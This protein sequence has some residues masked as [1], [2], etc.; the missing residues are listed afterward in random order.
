M[1]VRGLNFQSLG[2]SER[3][4]FCFKRQ[5]ESTFLLEAELDFIDLKE[6]IFLT[7]RDNV[8]HFNMS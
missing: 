4:H 6:N 5:T 1:S 3:E 8:L 2:A 7:H